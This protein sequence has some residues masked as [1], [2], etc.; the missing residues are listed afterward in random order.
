MR[1]PQ[2]VRPRLDWY[3][4]ESVGTSLPHFKFKLH[5]STPNMAAAAA[6]A[7]AATA[8]MAVVCHWVS[9]FAPFPCVAT[10]S[11]FPFL[12]FLYFLS[13]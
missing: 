11:T 1:G 12:G 3:C 8:V 13:L 9:A 10:L 7:A 6:V 2:G 5:V 4:F